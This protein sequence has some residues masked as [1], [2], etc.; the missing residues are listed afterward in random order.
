MLD[1]NKRG[2]DVRLFVQKLEQWLIETL[3]IFGI[4]GERRDG[5][6][7]IWVAHDDQEKKIAAIGV[8]IRRWIS[9]HGIS[10]NVAPDLSHYAG[11]VPCG[12]SEHGVTS[13]ADLGV[14]AS[15]NQVDEALQ[16]AFHKVFG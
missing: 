4:L 6:V 12:I 10:L 11:I 9:Y 1:L 13:L 8:R 5:R 7:G 15:M 16:T 14:T 3:A 2:R